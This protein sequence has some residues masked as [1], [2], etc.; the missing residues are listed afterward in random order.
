MRQL[1]ARFLFIAIVLLFFIYTFANS[2]N[3]GA[4]NISLSNSN[5][6]VLELNN[7]NAWNGVS[8]TDKPVNSNYQTGSPFINTEWQLASPD[9]N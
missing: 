9:P 5:M 8:I 3:S 1:Q 4:V 7:N 6:G 2:Q